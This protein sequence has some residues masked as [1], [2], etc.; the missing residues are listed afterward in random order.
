MSDRLKIELVP[1]DSIHPNSYNPNHQTD[2]QFALLLESMRSDGFTQPIVVQEATKVIVDGEHRWRAAQALGLSMVPVVF[3]NLSIEQQYRAT[4]QHNWA[5]GRE[6]ASLAAVIMRDLL[7]TMTPDELASQLHVSVDD[8]Q[9]EIQIH[10]PDVK[11][12]DLFPDAVDEDGSAVTNGIPANV[13]DLLRR[14]E[15]EVAENVRQEESGMA[16]ADQDL[17]FVSFTFTKEEH[18]EVIA[19]AL[20][21]YG[22]TTPAAFLALC[23]AAVQRG[24]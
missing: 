13:A 4:L 12:S 23:R 5:R 1:V 19:P 20:T 18:A 15:A 6:D 7:G 10:M 8:I 11:M 22:D 14:K 24:W 16:A 21:K 2:E 17:Y 3:V 9:L